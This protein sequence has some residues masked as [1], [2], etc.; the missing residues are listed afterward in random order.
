MAMDG[1]LAALAAWQSLLP[2]TCSPPGGGGLQAAPLNTAAIATLAAMGHAPLL[3]ARSAEAAEGELAGTHL[4]AFWAALAS[5]PPACD[6]EAAVEATERVLLG[7]LSALR[8]ALAGQAAQLSGLARALLRHGGAHLHPAAVNALAAAPGR[9]R[10]RATAALMAGAP[11]S[12]SRPLARYYSA[13]LGALHA[14]WA[15]AHGGAASG[16]DDDDAMADGS[17]EENVDPLSAAA[18][19]AAAGAPPAPGLGS[20]CRRRRRSSRAPHSSEAPPLPA[21]ARS[22]AAASLQ[23]I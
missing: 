12:V 23:C 6:S 22:A 10:Q 21:P 19:A 17:D 8:A 1:G 7:A 2:A 13:K 18:A 3:A 16:D 20:S 14:A 15:A 5:L 4:P 9:H 11:L